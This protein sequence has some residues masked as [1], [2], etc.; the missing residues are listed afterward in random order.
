MPKISSYTTSTPALTDKLLG[1]DVDGTPS[2]ATKNFTVEGVRDTILPETT[3]E[4]PTL[5]D[6]VFGSNDSGNPRTPNRNF[7]VEGIRNLI[8]PAQTATGSP[9]L[10]LRILANDDPISTLYNANKNFT[11][12]SLKNLIVPTPTLVLDTQ[13]FADQELTAASTKTQVSFGSAI[14]NTNIDLEANGT[15]N[16]LTAGSYSVRVAINCGSIQTSSGDQHVDY[17]FTV[18]KDGT[19]AYPTV[20]NTVFFDASDFDPA[21]TLIQEYPFYN[22]ATNT[23]LQFYWSG[24]VYSNAPNPGLFRTALV[25][26][27]TNVT[28]MLGVASA[29]IQIVKLD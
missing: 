18:D 28:G 15:V 9:T 14:T 23:V 25:N 3:T 24:S 27:P 5:T 26:K 21:Q 13:N 11:V 1:T 2:N 10:G 16:I 17:Y 6:K 20:Q 22:V 29:A 4:T 12:L 8:T 7:T 19:Q